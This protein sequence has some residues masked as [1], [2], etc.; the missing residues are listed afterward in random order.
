[1]AGHAAGLLRAI[2]PARTAEPLRV[3]WL[4]PMRALASDTRKALA[5]PLRDL[6]PDW[7]IGLRTGDTP[8]RRARAAGPAL[9]HGAVTTPESLSLMLTREHAREELPASNTW[10]STNGTS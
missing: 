9:S 3:I 1:V 8:E 5:E 4:T 7:T 2:R 6:A 10:W